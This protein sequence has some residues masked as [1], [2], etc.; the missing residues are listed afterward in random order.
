MENYK[1]CNERNI[2]LY[3]S[4][5]W[6]NVGYFILWVIFQGYNSKAKIINF[7][8]VYY[9]DIFASMGKNF[10]LQLFRRYQRFIVKINKKLVRRG[11]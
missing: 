2:S 5:N 3:R 11:I 7:S 10:H 8:N 4:S 1:P 6:Y 9:I